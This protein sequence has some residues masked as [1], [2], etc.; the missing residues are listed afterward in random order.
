MNWLEAMLAFALTMVALSTMVTAIMEVFHRFARSR[1]AGF[2]L[3]TE[4]LFDVVI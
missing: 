4:Q 3:M 2:Q 1:E